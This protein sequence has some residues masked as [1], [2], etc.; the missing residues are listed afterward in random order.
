MLSESQ[1]N[2]IQEV[3]SI[4]YKSLIDILTKIDLGCDEDGEDWEMVLRELDITR[5]D[6]DRE[7][8]QTIHNFEKVRKNPIEVFNLE[9]LDMLV[10]RYIL[11]N[12][13]H[14]WEDKY[15][16][17]LRNLW[18]KLFLISASELMS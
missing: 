13:S 6:L 18:N 1:K 2:I 3:C 15:P 11:F 8:V 5:A 7:L 4:Q 16:N 12:W 10:F 14:Y 17:A 9:P